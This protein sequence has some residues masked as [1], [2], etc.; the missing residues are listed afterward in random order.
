MKIYR[1]AS[2]SDEQF[3]EM[4]GFSRENDGFEDQMILMINWPF[5]R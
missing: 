2:M 1:I 3:E 5:I 4:W